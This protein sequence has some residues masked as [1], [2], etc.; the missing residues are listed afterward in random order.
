MRET[1]IV[2]AIAQGRQWQLLVLSLSRIFCYDT[3]LC[4]AQDQIIIV[5]YRFLP[6]QPL[7]VLTIPRIFR[8]KLAPWERKRLQIERERMWV[9]YTRHELKH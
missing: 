2:F 9:K 5:Y 1:L 4:L 7:T 8:R 6:R 3:D